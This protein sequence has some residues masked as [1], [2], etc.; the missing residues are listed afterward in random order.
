M[1]RTP[2][3][4]AEQKRENIRKSH[5]VL[6]AAVDELMFKD[7]IAVAYAAQ[8]YVRTWKENQPGAPTHGDRR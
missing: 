4:P 6:V 7:P 5:A 3:T 8:S 2:R 1:K